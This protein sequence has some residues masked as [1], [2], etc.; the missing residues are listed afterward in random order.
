ML[1]R[2]YSRPIQNILTV[3][4]QDM[5]SAGAADELTHIAASIQTMAVK[6][7]DTTKIVQ[8]QS[9]QLRREYLRKAL[10]SFLAR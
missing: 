3:L 10:F 8:Q 1:V 4:P 6:L 7:N 2:Y 5:P 9:R